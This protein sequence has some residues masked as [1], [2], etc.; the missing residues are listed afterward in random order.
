MF[1][2]RKKSMMTPPR[3]RMGCGGWTMAAFAVLVVVLVVYDW[4][5]GTDWNAAGAN[6]WDTAQTPLMIAGAVILGVPLA[7]MAVWAAV[8]DSPQHVENGSERPWI[9]TTAGWAAWTLA[10]LLTAFWAAPAGLVFGVGLWAVLINRRGC[11]KSQRPVTIGDGLAAVSRLIRRWWIFA[12]VIALAVA[13]AWV[14][15][16]R[17]I[18]HADEVRLWAGAAVMVVSI[19]TA[20]MI[21]RDVRRTADLR[22]LKPVIARHVLGIPVGR[23][24]DLG[25]KVRGGPRPRVELG[26]KGVGAPVRAVGLAEE[27]WAE[28][29]RRLAAHAPTLECT[30]LTD[31]GIT[32]IG[33][34]PDTEAR[35]MLA[36][37]TQ[38]MVVAVEG[39]DQTQPVA[40]ATTNEGE[41]Q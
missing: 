29:D 27:V 7:V 9:T 37:Q 17:G 34:S 16:D 1:G 25:G 2:K 33:V 19:T 3:P 26:F 23:L 13:A 14:V 21:R 22:A 18:G 30:S 6:V 41:E 40:I 35:R 12:A 39:V 32:L 36:E 10:A 15:I 24:G 28:V 8:L 31:V 20:A 38:G 5:T 4:I 11:A